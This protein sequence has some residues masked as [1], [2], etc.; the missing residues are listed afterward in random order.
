MLAH[1][2]S[3][4]AVATLATAVLVGGASTPAPSPA[5]GDR[6]AGAAAEGADA[7]TAA[8]SAARSFLD[9]YVEPD[10]RVVRHDQGGDTV[11]EGQAYALLIAAAVGDADAFDAIR[12]WTL[13][14]LTTD[15]GLLAFRWADGDIADPMA[16]ADAD[17]ISA[18]ALVL[19]ADRFDDRSM[20][21]DAG[22]IADAIVA[23]EVADIGGQTVLL[24]G[25]WA[26]ADGI[27][28][29]S[30]FVL[31]AMSLLAGAGDHRWASIAAT[32]RTLAAELMSEPPHLPP[33][34]AHVA[35]DDGRAEGLRVEARAVPGGDSTVYGF[36]AVRL[37]VQLAADC[38]P[39][40]RD[41]AARTWPFLAAEMAGGTINA[42]YH[43]DGSPASDYPH[44]ASLVAAASAAHAAGDADAAA[45]LLDAATELDAARPTYYGAVWIALTRLWL[46]TDLLSPCAAGRS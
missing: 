5:V 43:L 24:A 8:R 40:G 13:D 36:E 35:A 25:P 14:H 12:R 23:G 46:D 33:D 9:R 42:S 6:H 41:L 31:P 22:R 45:G 38:D 7:V 15:S 20:L 29:P 44:P 28:N 17:L 3:V 27:V 1:A 37:I 34:W 10:G 39:V 16:A 30:Y 18:A 4:V 26:R 19:A 32:S 11:S 21:L 2:R